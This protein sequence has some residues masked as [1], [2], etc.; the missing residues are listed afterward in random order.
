MAYNSSVW[1]V[2][3]KNGQLWSRRMAKFSTVLLVLT[4]LGKMSCD[5]MPDIE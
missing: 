4:N 5:T 1:S 2:M 3:I